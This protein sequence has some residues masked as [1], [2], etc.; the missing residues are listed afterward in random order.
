MVICSSACLPIR[1][2][3]CAQ[4]GRVVFLSAN[5]FV[6]LDVHRCG[7]VCCIIIRR[8]DHGG[9]LLRIVSP[10]SDGPMKEPTHGLQGNVVSPSSCSHSRCPCPQP[11][12][13]VP[14]E[15]WSEV[16]QM[17]AHVLN[18]CYTESAV[19]VVAIRRALE[20]H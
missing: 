7:R 20:R 16:L 19:P 15:E 8:Y 2:E 17:I 3:V 12:R 14:C 9:T 10:H 13:L 4:Q 6:Q 1:A 5:T 11:A 18:D